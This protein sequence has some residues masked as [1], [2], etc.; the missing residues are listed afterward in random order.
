MASGQTENYGLNQWAA[1]DAVLREEFN[2]D[3]VK[4]DAEL[5]QKVNLL[6]GTYTGNAA[7][8]K[9]SYTQQIELGFRPKA[10]IVLGIDIGMASNYFYNYTA[11][12]TQEQ[13]F[14]RILTV[15]DTGFTAGQYYSNTSGTMQ[16]PNMNEKNR[17]YLYLVFS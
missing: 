11:L 7:D 14:S 6:F 10:V 2:R 3:N 8:S 4:M 16:Y 15:N 5:A 9:T 13:G 12:A 17:S 1:E